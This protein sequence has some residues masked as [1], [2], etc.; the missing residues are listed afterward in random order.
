MRA[1]VDS[2][3]E[4]EQR[5]YGPDST[6][7][8][9]EAIARRASLVDDRILLIH[10]IAVQSP[11]S[12]KVMFER[13]QALAHDWDRFAYVVDL[14][15]AKRPDAETRAALKAEILGISPRVTH[16]AVAVGDN[17]LMRAMA[18]LFAYGMGLTNV[19]V[20]ATRAEAIEEP[21]VPWAGNGPT[22]R[23]L[24]HLAE[25]G[26]GRCTI[27][28]DTVASERDPEMSQV[29]LGL[30]VLYED[31]SYTSRQRTEAETALRL[32]AEQRARL[33]ED[34][35][36]AIAARDQFLAVVAHE[37]RTPLATLTLL[38]DC[39]IMPL[40]SHSPNEPSDVVVQKRQLVML[41]RQVERLTTLVVEM[42]DVSRI[43]G[44]GLQ[45]SLGPGRSARCRPSGTRPV[46]SR[47]SAPPYHADG[48]R[49]GPGAWDM[50]C[51]A[52]RSGDHAPD[53]ERA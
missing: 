5:R 13:F 8:E 15:E 22:D 4:L 20:H 12:V 40:H 19:S 23:I 7:E 21:G 3:V 51:R 43:T 27:T 2:T 17:Q 35:R 36:Q 6:H 52:H 25:I 42:L 46:R 18:R 30:L 33:L 41:K 31:L 10:E 1:P 48:E 26:A 16:L 28:D 32:V 45:L 24:M 37:L 39:L 53:L 49:A 47:Y 9:R 44:G 14:T 11:F 34:R 38:V 29:L 50:G